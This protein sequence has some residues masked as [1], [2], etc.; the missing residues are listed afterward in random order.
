MAL[1]QSVTQVA[2]G[3]AALTGSAIL[4]T[5]PAG[6]LHHMSDVALLALGITLLAPPL[7]WALERRL[8]RDAGIS[9][10]VRAV[11][12]GTSGS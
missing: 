11:M 3:I 4:S 12:K 2:G 8:P 6:E 1:V 7:I 9:H 5:G 10:R